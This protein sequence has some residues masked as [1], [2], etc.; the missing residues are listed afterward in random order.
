M[1]APLDNVFEDPATGS[2]SAALAAYRAALLPEQDADL[3]L[4]IEPGVDMGRPSQISLQ[5]HKAAG[6]V[7]RVVVGGNCVAVMR[8]ELTLGEERA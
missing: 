5:V 4:T 6:V 2:A 1:F 7:K 8:G 3:T